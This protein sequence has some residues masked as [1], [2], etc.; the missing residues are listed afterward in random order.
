MTKYDDK[1]YPIINRRK[2]RSQA[3]VDAVHAEARDIEKRAKALAESDLSDRE[4]LEGLRKLTKDYVAT[5][6]DLVCSD[7]FIA[8]SPPTEPK[9][10]DLFFGLLRNASTNCETSGDWPDA[11]L[12]K[13]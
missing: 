13:T 4:I 9:N 2:L 7:G 8:K 1:G 11:D 6:S 10:I 5:F 3:D 12:P